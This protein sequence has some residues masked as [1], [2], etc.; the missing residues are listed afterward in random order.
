MNENF[1]LGC[2]GCST[3]TTSTSGEESSGVR[4]RLG[5][6]GQVSVVRGKIVGVPCLLL[7]NKNLMA[8]GLFPSVVYTFS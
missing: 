1:V 3:P 7:F 8:H 6:M 4:M 2:S 5:C